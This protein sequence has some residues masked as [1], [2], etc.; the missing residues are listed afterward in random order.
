[1]QSLPS[2]AGEKGLHVAA[3]SEYTGCAETS[4]SLPSRQCIRL[5][6]GSNERHVTCRKEKGVFH[7]HLRF[8]LHNAWSFGGYTV[9]QLPRSGAH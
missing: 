5:S 8:G 4:V 7:F 1:M 9:C 3:L 6:R 2:Y